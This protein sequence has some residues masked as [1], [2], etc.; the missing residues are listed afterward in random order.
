MLGLPV[1]LLESHIGIEMSP[2][3]I[4]V[5]AKL[6]IK[7]SVKLFSRLEITQAKQTNVFPSTAMIIV[8]TRKTFDAVEDRLM[9]SLLVSVGVG[10]DSFIF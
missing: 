1:R 8:K 2:T 9:G 4:S 10:C 5:T 6:I 7:G 3:R